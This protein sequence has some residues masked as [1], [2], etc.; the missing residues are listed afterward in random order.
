[1][2]FNSILL[3]S[4]QIVFLAV[5]CVVGLN[6]Q[7]NAQDGSLDPTFSAPQFTTTT[8][9]GAAFPKA[10]ALAL[11]PDGKIIVGGYFDKVNGVTRFN[12]ARFNSDGSL[13]TTFDAGSSVKSEDAPTYGP[14]SSIALQPDGKMLIAGN[15]TV[16]E[17]AAFDRLLRLNADGSLDTGFNPGSSA[18]GAIQTVKVQPDGKI[19]IV[20]NFFNFRGYNHGGIERLNADGTRDFNFNIGFFGFPRPV[21][22]FSVEV[23]PDGK[24]LAG[25]SFTTYNNSAR[26]ALVRLNG[27]GYVD[28]PFKASILSTISASAVYDTKTQPDGKILVGGFFQLVNGS[29]SFAIARLRKDSTL[30]PTF[31]ALVSNQVFSIELQPDGQ[32]LLGGNNEVNNAPR[33]VARI[34]STGI[35]DNSFLSAVRSSNQ[36]VLQPDGKVLN[37]GNGSGNGPSALLNRLLNTVKRTNRAADFDGDGKTDVSVARANSANN[38]LTW[39][40]QNSSNNQFTGVPFGLASDKIAAADFDGD[41][42]TDIAVFRN[43]AWFVL[44]SSTNAFT[45]MQLGASGDIPMPGDYDGDGKAD[46]AVFSAG[47]WRILNSATN[48][49]RVEQFGLATDK[50]VAGNFDGDNKQ[51]LAVYR[52]GTWYVQGSAAGFSAYQFGTNGDVPVAADYDGDGK[53]DFAVYRPAN[54]IW[55]TQQT[56][57]GFKTAQF[58]LS[59]DTPTPADY[60][61]DGRADFAVYRNGT[62]FIL[63]AYGTI[64][65]NQFGQTGDAPLPFAQNQ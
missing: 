53:T 17:G 20:G 43:G 25:G 1:M 65:Y 4:K 58:G 30:D 37:I 27:N 26:N 28:A 5:F 11:Q 35:I 38:S 24:I 64:N 55:Y 51:D 3:K 40:V 52:N 32:I 9:S 45:S 56:T 19:L 63:T 62:W 12:V 15:F 57:A 13:D 7:A 44:N 42:K 31:N 16:A 21:S 59:S 6:I 48:T 54:G 60:D 47:T 2:L 36:I 29:P 46:A 18:D 49:V 39:F 14:I 34:S 8:V 61:G 33:A 22:V 10:A 50:P 23:Q 41:G